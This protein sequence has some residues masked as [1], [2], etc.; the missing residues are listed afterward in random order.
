ML[1]LLLWSLLLFL[2]LSLLLLLG[3]LLPVP[4]ADEIL[5]DPSLFFKV[6]LIIKAI[7]STVLVRTVVLR[8]LIRASGLAEW[9]ETSWTHVTTEAHARHFRHSGDSERLRHFNA[10]SMAKSMF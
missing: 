7:C 3:P 1:L 2:G 8:M 10:L 5:H 4:T 6:R 9:T